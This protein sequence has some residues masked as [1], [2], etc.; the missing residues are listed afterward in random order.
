MTLILEAIYDG[1]V[2]RPKQPLELAPNTIVKVT[3]ETIGG[4][5]SADFVDACLT[6]NLDGPEDWSENLDNYLYGTGDEGAE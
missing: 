2:L 5:Y 4:A 6:A 3:V 1:S